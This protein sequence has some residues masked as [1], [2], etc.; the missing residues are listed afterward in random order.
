MSNVPNTWL[1][2]NSSIYYADGLIQG[3]FPLNAHNIFDLTKLSESLL[4]ADK[5]IT[6]PGR[7]IEIETY[8]VLKNRFGIIEELNV[9]DGIMENIVGAVRGAGGE[10]IMGG[11]GRTLRDG[12]TFELFDKKRLVNIF[13]D[14]FGVKDKT[15][16]YGDDWRIENSKD[17]KLISDALSWSPNWSNKNWSSTSYY[18]DRWFK[19]RIHQENTPL[20]FLKERGADLSEL[21][22]PSALY[23]NMYATD[24]QD[25]ITDTYLRT[26]LYL[27]VASHYQLNYSPDS[28]RVPLVEYIDNVLLKKVKNFAL[29]FVAKYGNNDDNSKESINNIS[30]EMNEI[31]LPILGII[32]NKMAKSNNTRKDFLD[33]ILELREEKKVRNIREILGVL[34]RANKGDLAYMKEWEKIKK[35][36]KHIKG[37][38]HGDSIFVKTNNVYDKIG[39]VLSVAGGAAGISLGSEFIGAAMVGLGSI[40]LFMSYFK[41]RRFTLLKE[42]NK[43]V[44]HIVSY[45][46][47]LEKIFGSKLTTNQVNILRELNA[48]QKKYIF[49]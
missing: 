20:D 10:V 37:G 16:T 19:S 22:S 17:R 18:M 42:L 9:N 27:E 38:E 1:I 36:L 39:P 30:F 40:P 24:F 8:D 43:E 23:G 14:I 33:T 12:T 7:V 44:N 4:L 5:I 31:K 41:Q 6:L 35:E 29:A 34:D 45:N 3:N 25:M 48:T 26:I 13:S 2:S 15:M 46:N 32:I 21:S 47:K 28:I 49:R 11:G